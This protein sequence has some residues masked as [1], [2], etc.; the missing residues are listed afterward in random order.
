MN[1]VIEN[2]ASVVLY[3]YLKSNCLENIFALPANVCPIVPLTFI[4]AGVKYKFV[5]ISPTTHAIDKEITKELIISGEVDSLFYVHAYGCIVNNEQYY[6]EMKAIGCK[7]I[8]EDKCLCIPSLPE[9]QKEGIA[10]L[11]LYST[12]YAKFVEFG[13]GGYGLFKGNYERHIPVGYL[14]RKEDDDNIFEEIRLALLQNKHFLY[15]RCNWLDFTFYTE[16]EY[17][18]RIEKERSKV[19]EHKAMINSIYNAS[20]PQSI[21][22]GQEFTNW[23]YMILSESRDVI[24]SSLFDAGFFA[25]RNYPSV[26]YLFDEIH[27]PCAEAE[28]KLTLN[29]FNDFR[30][31]EEKAIS[32]ANILHRI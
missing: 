7:W 27:S 8:I 12:G 13:L 31:N 21:Q 26:S 9:E 23:R 14:Y 4:T 2:R 29:L 30:I 22:M 11:Y 28:A 32:I 15:R 6:Q 20:V 17:F 10:D 25:G 5:D 3:N 19:L 24:I 1:V 18:D 16:S